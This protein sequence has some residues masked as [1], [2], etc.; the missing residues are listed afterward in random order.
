MP[1]YRL[2]LRLSPLNDGRHTQFQLSGS[3][4]TAPSPR[5]LRSLLTMLAH[6]NGMPVRAVLSAA[7]PGFCELWTY[8]LMDVPARHLEVRFRRP[9]RSIR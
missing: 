2:Q 4:F 1:P 3:I 8:A 7:D 6:W 9:R 5:Q